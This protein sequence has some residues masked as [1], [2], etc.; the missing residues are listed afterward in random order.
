SGLGNYTNTPTFVQS[1][2]IDYSDPQLIAAMAATNPLTTFEPGTAWSYSN[3]AYVLVGV[4]VEIAS[5]QPYATF[6][7]ERLFEPI[8]LRSTAVDDAAEI[9]PNRVS[10]YTPNPKA[11]SGFANASF[12]SMTYPGGAGDLR[13]TPE[14]LCRWHTALLGGRVLRAESLRAMLTPVRLRDGSLPFNKEMAKALGEDKPI[15]YGFG[16]GLGDF[17]GHHYVE[18]GGGIN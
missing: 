5:Q 12:I 7:R 13:S 17:E 10:G 16:I 18:H 8:G 11:A 3:T 15:E 6:L 2:R 1:A 4:V 14:D 9:V